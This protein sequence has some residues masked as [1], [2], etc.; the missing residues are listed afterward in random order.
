MLKFINTAKFTIA[1]SAT[2]LLGACASPSAS[3]APATPPQAMVQ[4]LDL[5]GFDRTL[6]ASLA[7]PLPKVDVA[8]VDV[9]KPS[10]MPERL[11][12][13]MAAVEAGGG[14][15]AVTPPKSTVQGKSLFALVSAA[16]T[17]WSASKMAASLANDAQFKAANAYNAEIV[18][19]ADASGDSVVDKVVFTKR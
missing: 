13:W 7:A 2:A 15:V 16:T 18:L 1:L 10:A 11:Q 19:K 9:V 12:K 14:K 8:F 6:S 3:D 4:F 5:Q 17:V